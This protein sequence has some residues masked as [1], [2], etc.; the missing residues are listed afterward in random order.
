MDEMMGG[1][2]FSGFVRRTAA[3]TALAALLAG[4]GIIGGKHGPVTPTV[5]NR[6][7]ILSHVGSDV[8][9]DPT[10]A[11]VA[12]VLPPAQVNKDWSTA[13]GEPDKSIGHVALGDNPARVW[14]AQVAGSSNK[15]RLAAAPVVGNGTLYVVDT[16]GAVNAF[17]AATGATRWD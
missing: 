13:G 9:P 7:P 16:N 10:L 14:T 6:T 4:C 11:Q 17:D 2:N 15:E 3:L 1:S 5:G 8:S 12:V